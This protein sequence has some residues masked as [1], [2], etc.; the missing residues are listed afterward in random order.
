MSEQCNSKLRCEWAFAHLILRLWVGLRLFMAGLD[1]MRE[2]GGDGFGL[3]YIAKSMAPIVDTISKNTMLPAFAIKPYALVLPWALLI[4]GLLCVLG[5]CTRWA[6]LIGGLT[7]VSL[8][9]G[10]MALPDDDQAVYRGIEVALTAFAL[11]TAAHNQF[12]VDALL[13]RK[14]GC[15]AKDKAAE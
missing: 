8:A 5:I 9:V 2:K 1:K 6:L 15:C 11:V 4:S 7:F 12:S 14:G 13:F 10:L 3:Q